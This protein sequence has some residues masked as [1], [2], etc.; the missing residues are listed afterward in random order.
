M[1]K[2]ETDVAIIGGGCAGMAAAATAAERGVR[3]I[4]FEKGPQLAMGGER[5]VCRREQ[6]ATHEPDDIYRRGCFPILY[7]AHSLP[8][9]R[10]V[11]ESLSG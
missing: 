11:A 7:A 4:A 9:R 8:G 5:A 3:V 2:L 10:Q 6:T 1:K